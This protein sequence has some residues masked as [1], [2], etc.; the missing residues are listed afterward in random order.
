[1][2]LKLVPVTT[3]WWSSDSFITGIVSAEFSSYY[4][5]FMTHICSAV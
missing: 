3:E 1:M 2:Y 5:Q 4:S